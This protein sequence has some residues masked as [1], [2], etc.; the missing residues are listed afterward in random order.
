[1]REDRVDPGAGPAELM[2]IPPPSV[3][4]SVLVRLGRLHTPHAGDLARATAV[5]G[6]GASLRHACALAGVDLEAGADALDALTEAEL[7]APGEPLR[8]VHPLVRAAVYSDIPE[9]RRALRHARA[10]QLLSAEHAQPELVALHHLH[11]PLAASRETVR[12]L[13]AAA[14]RASANGAPAGAVRYLLRALAEPPPA[15]DRVAI[16]VELASAERAVGDRAAVEHLN[17]ALEL[18]SQPDVRARLY[19]GLGWAEHDAGRFDPAADAFERGLALTTSAELAGVLE[20]GFLMS[21]TLVVS[22]VGEARERIQMIEELGTEHH[23]AAHR[24]LLAQVLFQR[25]VAGAPRDGIIELAERLWAGGGL[26]ADQGAGSQALW[27][28]VG[29]LSWADAYPQALGVI[30]RVLSAADE[31]GNALVRAQAWY[32]R[33]WPYLWMGRVDAAA[34]DARGAIEIWQGGMERYLPA[35]IYY[36]GLAELE[37]DDP[38]A[39]AAALALAGPPERW[40]GT[41]MLPFLIAL[42]GYIHAHA[43]RPARA[44]ARQLACGEA[45]E[46]LM[47]TSPAVLPWRSQAALAL[48]L[49]GEP[50][51]ARELLDDELERATAT[52]GPRPIGVALRA[53]GI[54]LG[55]SAGLAQLHE[56]VTVL[57]GSG[58]GLELAR[59]L[60]ELGATIRRQGQP[61]A[62]RPH[63][64][65]A[66]EILDGT[67]ARVTSRRADTELRAAGGRGRVEALSG[68][69]ALTASELRVAELAADGHTNRHIAAVLQVSV[70]AV[71]WHLHQSYRKLE[72]DGRRQLAEA[73]AA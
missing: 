28:V 37:R 17:A 46:A 30:D 42:E 19:L 14:A 54:C 71:E 62:A 38:E 44:A 49:S 57:D 69:R 41:G 25:T 29:A 48:Q 51:R 9:G 72:I 16:L 53:S 39:A 24:E 13:R 7:L 35:A 3:T 67:G 47:V 63:L 64:E 36:L 68:P 1:L 58:A 40:E 6:D 20:A 70:K 27:H 66:L 52:G 4:R 32:A 2:R 15:E 11:A 34:H 59:S 65:R 43:G 50:A 26:L 60:V 8:F 61:R 10:A 23:N 56:S 21:A 12:V 73:L 55:G 5:L 31:I 18:T 45:L 22:R 33:S